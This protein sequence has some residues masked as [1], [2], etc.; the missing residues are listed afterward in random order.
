MII[1]IVAMDQNHAI[2]RNHVMPWHIKEEL[3]L[4]KANTMGHHLL[5]GRVTYENLPGPLPGRILHIASRQK[6]EGYI[7]DIDAFLQTFQEKRLFIAGG[8]EIYERSYPYCNELWI[9]H[10]K[11]EYDA[12]TYFTLPFEKD[13][14]CYETVEYEAF[15]FCKW[16]RRTS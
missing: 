11:A 4:F 12:D 5:M 3:Q 16:R 8:A 15:V 10:I 2:G 14:E 7:Q 6:K 1:A 13:F 9:S